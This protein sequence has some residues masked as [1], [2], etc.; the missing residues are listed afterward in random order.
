LT[1][2]YRIS[3]VLKDFIQLQ[4][5]KTRERARQMMIELNKEKED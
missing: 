4:V 2:K 3:A 1:K 5:L